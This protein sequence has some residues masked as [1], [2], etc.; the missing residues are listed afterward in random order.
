MKILA[1]VAIL[2]II[3]IVYSHV[4]KHGWGLSTG[5]SSAKGGGKSGQG[6]GDGSKK[7]GK[8]RDEEKGLK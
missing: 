4:S 6:P 3:W 2:A 1:V 5:K 7:W 8:G